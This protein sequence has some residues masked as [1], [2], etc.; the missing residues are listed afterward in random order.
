[1]GNDE[2]L[3]KLIKWVEKWRGN[4]PEIKEE[5]LSSENLERF[6]SELQDEIVSVIDDFGKNTIGENAKLVLYSG[7]NPDVVREF[8]EASDGEYYMISQTVANILWNGVFQ[9]KIAE[10]IGETKPDDPITARVLSGKTNG[11]K[12]ERI[13]QYAT[14]SGKYLSLDDFISTKVVEAGLKNGKVLYLLG[15]SAN[16]NSVGLLTEIPTLMN[17]SNEA[18]ISTSDYLCLGTGLTKNADGTFSFKSVDWSQS[19]VFLDSNGKVSYVD[20]LESLYRDKGTVGDYVSKW[21]SKADSTLKMDYAAYSKLLETMSEADILNAIRES[22]VYVNEVGEIVGRSFKGTKLNGI[23]S[24]TIPTEYVHEV[25]YDIFIRYTD[26]ATMVRDWG[27]GY[28]SLPASDKFQLKEADYLMRVAMGLAEPEAVAKATINYALGA[29]KKLGELNKLDKAIINLCSGLEMDGK[30]LQGLNKIVSSK[31]FGKV[32]GALGT[33]GNVVIVISAIT[34]IYDASQRANYAMSEG[35]FYEAAGI[36]AGSYTDFAISVGGGFLLTEALAPYL[37]GAG[38]IIAGPFGALVGGLLAGVI[39]FG[40]TEFVG[41]KLGDWIEEQWSSL[42]VLY[43]NAG[44]AVRYDPLVIDLD[45]DGF[46]LLS[47]KDGVYFDEDASG[48]MEKTAWVSSHDALLAIDLNGDGIINDGSELFGTSTKLANGTNA[49]SGFEALAQYDL[50][51]DGII[52]E[53]DEVFGRLKVWQDKNGD[54]ISQE[55]ELYSLDDLGIESI[56]LNTSEEDGR[57]T[58]KINYKDGSESKIGEFD[59]DSEL[60]NT[61]EKDTVEIS[62]EILGLPN[63]QAMGRVASLHTLM[64]LDETGILKGYVEQFA[65][66]L[67]RA[68]KEELLTKILYFITGADQ[69]AAG[70]RGSY[71]DA[72]KLAVIEQFMGRDF[73]G[74]RGANPVNT[75]AP[76][77]ENIY[78]DIYNAYY[79]MLNA[80]THL[81]NYM[82]LLFWTEDANGNK[83]INTDV[84]N[85]FISLCAEEGNDMTEVVAEIGRYILSIN[86][87][88]ESN[89]FDYLL[90][91]TDR[92][93]YA[94]AIAEVCDSSTYLG[95]D[96]NDSYSG[97]AFR[98]ILFGGGGS[99][100]LKGNDGN[101]VLYGEEGDDNLYGEDGEDILI[102]GT[103]NDYLYGGYGNDT[104]IFNLGDG[105]DII[106]EYENSRT[107]GKED[108]IVFGEGISV[109]D[110]R[111]RREGNNLII[112]YGD[113]DSVTVQNA[114]YYA[115]GR[116]CVEY[117]E[118]V[119]GTRLTQEDI[120]AA[121]NVRYGTDGADTITGYDSSYYYSADEEFHAGAGDDTVKGGKGNDTIY[122]EE[123]DDNLY[124]E[125]GEDILI[126]GTGNDY[127]YGGYGNDTYIF[128]L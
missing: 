121:V 68:E 29:G 19:S 93:D 74:T 18:G 64:Q 73:V 100:T 55:D 26:D 32:A 128:N 15:E 88:N 95:T 113:G 112:E 110:I 3:A 80:Q 108:R 65:A 99:D 45:G 117:I 36:F 101:D 114:Y 33:V 90:S 43:G 66:S 52:D 20:M 46:E 9:K 115:D 59:F 127:L 102:G 34:T 123:G 85:A 96:E 118:F 79:S 8:C 76:I 82:D 6:V 77:L 31:A 86:V 28:N 27:E 119:D 24:D 98:D 50:N 106:S 39:S 21:G 42:D 10:A 72:Q 78:E 44:I 63:I 49:R 58:A 57:L 89:F 94:K 7:V 91:Y 23:I 111:M 37:M 97:T 122:G 125:D 109:E 75:A 2:I 35:R 4:H 69:V 1:M 40:V 87:S 17:A 12:G 25:K 124:G 107:E 103:G 67:S 22:R 56:S 126:G 14:D 81:A 16:P 13:D 83:Y 51:G 84:F 71:F 30:V 53:N 38:M 41:D 5:K 104:Y 61:K 47:V 11:E 54:G 92:I 48:L 105:A 120:Q 60:Y 62:D 116:A 70:S